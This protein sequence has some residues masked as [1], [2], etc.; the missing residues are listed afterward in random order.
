MR[1]RIKVCGVRT[2]EIALAAVDAGADAVGFAFVR[3]SARKIEPHD[4]WAIISALPPFVGTVAVFV[5]PSLDMFSDAE[6]QCPTSMTQFSGSEDVQLVRQCGPGLIKGLRYHPSDLPDD[7]AKW[8]A[9]DEV[10]AILIDCPD[11]P[12]WP[13]LSKTLSAVTKPVILGGLSPTNVAAAIR[14]VRPYAVD[15]SAGVE[16]ERGVKDPAL[17]TAFCDAVRDADRG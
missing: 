3:A 9:V 5:S 2:A 6:E 8:D 15:T 10:D 11:D 4:A 17:I 13:V 7:L 16:G 14:E 12:D 1:T